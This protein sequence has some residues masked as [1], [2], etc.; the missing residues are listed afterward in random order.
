MKRIRKLFAL[1]VIAVMAAALPGCGGGSGG[2]VKQGEEFTL[3]EYTLKFESAAINGSEG[4]VTLLLKGASGV[5]VSISN[6]TITLLINVKLGEGP[7]EVKATNISINGT[8]DTEGYGSRIEYGFVIPEGKEYSTATVFLTQSE[9]NSVV[10]DLG[11]GTS[12]GGGK[13]G[14]ILALI[15][16]A[17]LGTAGLAAIM[18]SKKKKKAQA[19]A[20]VPETPGYMPAGAP[21]DPG[22]MPAAAPAEPGYAPYVT[23]VEPGYAPTV[24]PVEPGYA[25]PVTPVEPAPVAEPAQ[26]GTPEG[27]SGEDRQ[28]PGQK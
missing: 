28:G 5:P 3:G 8:E 18:L 15:G 20:A 26:P 2:G 22:Y 16:L 14:P 23:P 7:D 9:S 4:T 12:G 10:L 27:N 19:A 11:G 1:L 21:V 17:V 13:I 25:A 24:I 6:G